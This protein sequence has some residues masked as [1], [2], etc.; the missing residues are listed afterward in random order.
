LSIGQE[1]KTNSNN[2]DVQHILE[3]RLTEVSDLKKRTFKDYLKYFSPAI[4]ITL[5][6]F[7]VAYQFVQPAPPRHITIATGQ[8]G[9]GYYKLG[10]EY[11][12]ILARDK[13]LLTVKKTNGSVEN[14]QLL[15]DKNSGVDVI[16]MQ[17]GVGTMESSKEMVSLGSI[18]YEPLW[19]FYRANLSIRHLTDMRGM[20]IAVGLEGSGSKVLSLKLLAVNG[21]TPENS[22]FFYLSLV[23]SVEKLLAGDIDVTFFVVA[24][25]DEN[26]KKLLYSPNV[27]MLS[28]RRGEAYTQRFQYLSLLKVPEGAFDFGNNIPKEDSYL[29]APT[30]QLVTREDFHPAIIDLLLH[31][32]EEMGSPIKVFEKPG[33]FPA[34]LNLDFP[35]SDAAAQFYK[36]GSPFLQRH[37]PFWVA[38]FL[39]R[40]KILLLPLFGLLYPLI[41]FFPPF[42]KWRMRSRI[43]RWYDKLMK[44]DYEMLH[45]DI[46]ERKD[47]FISRLNEVE[48][49]VSKIS[50]PRGYSRELYDMRIHIEMLRRKLI[51]AGTDIFENVK[52]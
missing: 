43:F 17:G 19:V 34:P 41:K 23:E 16:F 50:V 6:G 22:R 20:K 7:L 33:E 46:I 39:I 49:Q 32:A 40:M 10:Q 14:L 2:I 36:H 24:T 5:V 52:K 27:K 13:V 26:T 37:F 51:E 4:L 3:I 29:L 38:N 12:R 8:P 1:T 31:A 21:V 30:A 42:Y 28:F 25:R 15:S 9:G 11:S 44:I 35:L 18:Y 48:Q 47:D 45:G